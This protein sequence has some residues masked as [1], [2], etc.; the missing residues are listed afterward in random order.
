MPIA[1][2]AKTFLYP[3][4]PGGSIQPGD[5]DYYEKSGNWLAQPKYNESRILAHVLPDGEVVFWTR[6]GTRP[7]KFDFAGL[8]REV[9]S[10]LNFTPGVEYWIDGGIMNR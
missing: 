6:H 9:A 3:P 1:A 4:R 10:N 2:P 8:A 5:L 7:T